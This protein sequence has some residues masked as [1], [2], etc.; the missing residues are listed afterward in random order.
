M[1][2]LEGVISSKEPQLK[3]GRKEDLYEI[4]RINNRCC[5]SNRLCRS[6][7]C[8]YLAYLVGSGR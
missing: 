4:V 7:L 2:R 3:E 6:I 8:T 5:Y 1:K